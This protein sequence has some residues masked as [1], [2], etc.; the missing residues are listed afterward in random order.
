MTEI[1]T[2]GKTDEEQ[3]QELPKRLASKRRQMICCR[4]AFANSKTQCAARAKLRSKSCCFRGS[5]LMP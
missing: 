2:E 5:F 1:T 3:K 4:M